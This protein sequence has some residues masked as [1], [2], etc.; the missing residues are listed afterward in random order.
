[1][2]GHSDVNEAKR[3]LR[4][5]MREMRRAL[6]DREGLSERLW[7]HVRALP[8][9]EVAAPVKVLDS[10]P[11]EPITGPFIEWCRRQGKAVALP[12]D[13]P[14]IDPALVDVVIVPGLAFTA[15]GERLGQG[16]GWSDRFLPQLRAGCTTVG[17]GFQAQL[18][19]SLPTEPHDVTLSI[20]VT[21]V[22]IVRRGM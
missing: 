8:E 10:I 22:G 7:G 14:P 6:S 3:R 1:M 16:G 19:E 4:R 18:V 2:T 13:D 12:E 17:V 9:V 21:D 11:G 20:V 15:D 5:E